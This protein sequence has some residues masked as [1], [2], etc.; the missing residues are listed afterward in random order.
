MHA[1]T[2][3]NHQYV[4][5]RGAFLSPFGR[6]ATNCLALP[7]LDDVPA[8]YSDDPYGTKWARMAILW[9]DAGELTDDDF[10]HPRELVATAVT[11][12]MHK[13]LTGTKYLGCLDIMVNPTIDPWDCADLHNFDGNPDDHWMLS[14]SQGDGVSWYELEPGITA[15]E[16]AHPGLGQTALREFETKVARLLPVLTPETAR[17]TA[18]NQW[19]YGLS[20][21]S[22]FKEELLAMYD[23]EEDVVVEE[24]LHKGPETFDAKFPEWMFVSPESRKTLTDIELQSIADAGTTSEARAVAQQLLELRLIDSDSYRLPWLFGQSPVQ[25]DNAYFSAYIRWNKDDLINQLDDDRID[26]ANV[27][28]DCFTDLLGADAI[29]FAQDGFTQWKSEI[30]AGFAVLRKLDTLLPLIAAPFKWED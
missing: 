27:N 11:R 12:W 28:G 9:L 10:G 8:D 14:V 19:W 24:W 21:Q 7:R 1:S 5:S 26:N 4:Q 15:L 20:T 29:P 16:D 22:D 6:S 17:I 13:Q 2:I 25:E 30:E 23:G 3:E 18:E